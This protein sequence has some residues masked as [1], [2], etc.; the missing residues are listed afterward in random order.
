MMV[1]NRILGII[2]AGALLMG[3]WS[4]R[5]SRSKCGFTNKHILSFGGKVCLLHA[6]VS[7]I[8]YVSTIFAK[9]TRSFR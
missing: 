1:E 7:I 3:I 5:A 6:L 2:G 9:K 4:N 8:F